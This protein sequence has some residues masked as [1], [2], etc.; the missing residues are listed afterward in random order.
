MRIPLTLRIFV[1]HLI[2][3]VTVGYAGWIAAQGA[4]TDY[5]QRWDR[6]VKT[7][8]TERLFT[9]MVAEVARSLLLR[10]EKG[11]PESK[12]RNRAEITEAVN[13]MLPTVPSIEQL[14]VLDDNDTIQY[15]NDPEQFQLY[16]EQRH[17]MD[18]PVDG[19]TGRRK[20]ERITGE[21]FTQDGFLVLGEEG[22]A[23]G[24]V[25]IQYALG[26]DPAPGAEPHRPWTEEIA[27]SLLTET[28]TEEGADTRRNVSQGLNRVVE[29]TPI[30]ALVVVDQSGR[31]QYVNEPESLDLT[32]PAGERQR[33]LDTEE[34]VRRTLE[35]P[36]GSEGVE[37]LIPIFV[38]EGADAVPRRL[39]SVVLRM[40]NDPDL[41]ARFPELLPPTVGFRNYLKPLLMLIGVAVG[42]G[43]LLAGLLAWPVRRL[44]TALYDFR[45]RG[46][47][48]D[49][50]P[51]H[52]VPGYLRETVTTLQ[53]MGGKLE[54]MDARGAEREA[55][56]ESLS[57]SLED[58]MVAVGPA[59]EALAWNEAALRLFCG[60]LESVAHEDP[61]AQEALEREAIEEALR[62][63][64]ALQADWQLAGLGS[65]TELEAVIAGG[66]RRPS[67]V[68]RVP[69]EWRP[70]LRGQL[71]LI[72]DL[73]TLRQVESHLAEAGRFAALTHIAAGLAHE[74]RNPL[75]AIHLN[76]G[77]VEQ[78]AA[79]GR[80]DEHV[81]DVGDSVAVIREEAKR[82][83]DLLNNY[84]GLVRADGDAGPFD[85]REIVRR[86]IQLVGYG[87]TQANVTLRVT[88]E[89][90][91]PLVNGEGK[92]MQQAVLNLV[93][94]AIQ[95][96][97][98]G[99]EVVIRLASGDGLVR[100]VVQDDGP[101]V[102][103]EVADKLF[104][105]RV[106]T[107]TGGSGLGLPLVQLV[108][109]SHGG[110]VRYYPAPEGGACF[111]VTLPAAAQQ[112]ADDAGRV[113]RHG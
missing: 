21:S 81:E 60:D 107:K 68:T 75:H 93:L 53:E 65:T 25:L 27:R 63:N 86:V 15:V 103:D 66:D 4:F 98:A 44:E 40:R 105:S 9:P 16:V 73:G 14:I 47:K 36:S 23:L 51:E 10:V 43:I 49:I 22:E 20:L 12:A 79:S 97:E 13:S 17:L 31:I 72:R 110:Q 69:V 45:K 6:Q 7:L 71:L 2:F 39:G 80:I 37:L 3:L 95:A 33:Q 108:V 70:G 94:N 26:E 102:P 41:I 55:L 78:Y 85:V 74:I 57:R 82:L 62:R 61:T 77:A 112:G 11:L 99:G 113:A 87:A 83:T 56:L 101:G 58:A 91:L 19:T 111:E 88:G 24:S 54:A 96:T 28:G 5:Q 104:S 42:G 38:E 59:G 50:D 106:T 89:T 30:E 1:V 52:R 100:L 76:A 84:L 48:G 46:F 92:R 34:V 109:E 67:R 32:Y 8:P 29:N 35:L 90:L 18:V 64:G